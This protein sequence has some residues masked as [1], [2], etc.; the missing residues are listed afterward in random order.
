M[1]RIG[2]KP[3]PIP[4]TVDVAV[5]GGSLCV[6]GPLG[7]LEMKLPK[8]VDV[9]L[10]GGIAS[11]TP[12]EPTRTNRGF[13]GL[14]RALLANMVQGVTQ[15]YERVLTINGVGYKAELQ[16][17]T[18]VCNLGFSH[19]K[20]LTLP[21]GIKAE[22]PKQGTS[23]KISGIDKQLVGQVAA[24]IRSFKIP[25]PY[26]AKG[27]KYADETIRRKVGKAGVK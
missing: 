10:D 1:S 12:P 7:N 17:D 15:G 22:V 5:K 23:V 14:A 9:T 25:E 24:Q 8:G 16:G 2:R 6:T 13:Q 21:A 18:L 27:V 4:A 3:V 11:V 26:K 20:S 19:Q